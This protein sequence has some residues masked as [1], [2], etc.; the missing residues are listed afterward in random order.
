LFPW[1]VVRNICHQ[2]LSKSGGEK[3]TYLRSIGIRIR[4]AF[5]D[6][7]PFDPG[8]HALSIA[9]FEPDGPSCIKGSSDG[10]SVACG[11]FGSLAGQ[12]D[13]HL[14]LVRR[15][16]EKTFSEYLGVLDSDSVF[17]TLQ[18]PISISFIIATDTNRDIPRKTE[19]TTL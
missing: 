17:R 6:P 7:A 11:K 12:L 9:R 1:V 16:T 2:Q 5:P 15:H 4:V 13:L 8:V 18:A 10:F 14:H 3:V 19:H